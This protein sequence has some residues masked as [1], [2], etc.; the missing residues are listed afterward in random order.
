MIILLLSK[1]Y[2]SQFSGNLLL[3][4][5]ATTIFILV[6]LSN[7]VSAQSFKGGINLGLV[8]SQ[9]A[10]DRF[11]GFNKAGI[12]GGPWVSLRT[13]VHTEFS[14]ELNYIQKGSRENP[15]YENNMIDSYIM[16]LG[17]IELPILYRMIY[18]EKLN[19][20]AG[21]AMDFLLHHYE[22]FNSEELNGVDFAKSNLCLI[23]GLSYNFN[24]KLRVNLRTN[25][26]IFSIRKERVD[27][28]VWRFFEHGQYNDAL[29]FALYYT[30]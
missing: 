30:L 27:G 14:M 13:A 15:D 2:S 25:N 3:K 9:V 7:S 17:Y 18:S 22:R 16:R 24:E 11:S 19:F 29:I 1:N 12:T 21:P 26:S 23:L 20:E 8:G 5:L 4:L 28:D 6:F 10:G